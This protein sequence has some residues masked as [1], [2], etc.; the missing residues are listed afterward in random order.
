MALIAQV[1]E[2]CKAIT[3]FFLFIPHAT[4]H[5]D[6]LKKRCMMLSTLGSW[7]YLMSQLVL[8][9]GI[10]YHDQKQPMGRWVY[11]ALWFQRGSPS[12]RERH[13]S[14]HLDQETQRYLQSTDEK[15]RANC[16]WG[17]A[18]NSQK[19]ISSDIFPPVSLHIHIIS[20]N[21]APTRDQVFECL[22]PWSTLLS[23]TTT[24][25]SMDPTGWWPYHKRKHISSNF[26]TR[27]S[28]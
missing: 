27:H 14:R 9:V 12:C 10:K 15:Q 2:H 23:Q 24:L 28:L 26:K 5:C 21:S 11:F 7:I 18:T 4:S 1:L 19:H 8:F 22:S 13:D 3:F 20:L 17:M 16:K 6:N 25:Y